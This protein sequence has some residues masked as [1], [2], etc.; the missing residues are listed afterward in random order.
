MV[1]GK[2][3]CRKRRSPSSKLKVKLQGSPSFPK[4]P[5]A[6]GFSK[7]CHL[8]VTAFSIWTLEGLKIQT[9]TERPGLQR[10]WMSGRKVAR[11][12]VSN[13]TL[14]SPLVNNLILYQKAHLLPSMNQCWQV[15]T[16]RVPGQHG[17]SP[18]VSF[19]LCILTNIQWLESLS[20]CHTEQSHCS[21]NH[22]CSPY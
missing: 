13:L 14:E 15:V 9:I 2:Q 22:Q 20:Y 4:G 17:G 6:E 5:I 19:S 21:G 1:V 7:W 11:F 10:S 3:N 16:T 12:T 8:L 18:L